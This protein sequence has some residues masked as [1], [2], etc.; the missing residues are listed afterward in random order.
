VEPVS[1]RASLPRRAFVSIVAVCTYT[2]IVLALTEGGLRILGFKP[3]KA[4]KPRPIAASSMPDSTLGWID[5]PGTYLSPEAGNVP[6]T[7]LAD[8]SRRS[9]TAPTKANQR[10]EVLVVGCS[11]TQ[12]FG[13]IDED[14]FSYRLNARYPQLMFHNFGT[15][16]YGTYQSLMRVKENLAR[17]DADHIPLVIYGFIDLHL[18]RN[19]ATANWVRSLG[20][21]R[22]QYIVPPHVRLGEDGLKY[23]GLQAISFWPLESD[24][25]LVALLADAWL[26]LRLRNH[27]SQ[28]PPTKALIEQMNQLVT[29]VR[30]RFLIVLLNRPP[31]G[32]VSFLVSQRIDYVNCDNPAFDRIPSAF[33]LGGSG[34]PNAAQNALWA[35]CI[36]D[37]IDHN[38][39]TLAT[40]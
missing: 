38:L 17:A 40:P 35:A 8:H 12:G 14:T 13:V 10:A 32:L 29:G 7:F 16:G 33:R 39:T 3:R 22:N 25:A 36:G 34:H 2:A 24:S 20:A 28:L 21:G 26:E 31:K 27:G 23:Y 19:V 4:D 1:S 11:F 6:M 9:W 30:K 5:R 15:G 18:Q 37:W